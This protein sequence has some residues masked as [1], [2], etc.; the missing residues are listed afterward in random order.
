MTKKYPMSLITSM[1]LM[2]LI[3]AVSWEW[4]KLRV[5][6]EELEIM[7]EDIILFIYKRKIHLEGTMN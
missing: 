6:Y 4:T 1:P 2:A 3:R 7:S 5:E